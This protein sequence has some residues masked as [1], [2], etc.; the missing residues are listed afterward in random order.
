VR[1][2]VVFAIATLI[3]LAFETTVPLWL[4]LGILAPNLVLIL[5]VDLGMKHHAALGA[6]M[7]FAMGYA[8]DAFSGTHLGLNAFV[9]TLV[10]LVAYW[11]SRYLISTSTAIGVFLVFIGTIVAGMANSVVAAGLG[12]LGA[13]LAMAP[14][15]ALKGA[16]GA[17]FTPLVFSLLAWGK[18]LVGLRIRTVRE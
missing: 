15:L 7:A 1:L 17:A 18:R 14:R 6:M 5:V 8:V 4:P 2:I 16:V 11:L 12:A 9:L 3:A 10:Y 13:A